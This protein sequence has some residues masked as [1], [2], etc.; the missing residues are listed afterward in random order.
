M[1]DDPH[2]GDRDPRTEDR[3]LLLDALLAA[4][5]RLIVTYTGNDE[6]TNI[7][8]PPAVP[9]GELLDVVD[10]TVRAADGPA[11]ERVVVRHPLQPFDPRNFTPGALAPERPWSFDRRHARRRAGAR[12]RPR[13]GPRR[14]S[15]SRC[16]RPARRS[17]SST[18]SSAS[19]STRCARSCASGSASALGDVSRRDRGRAAGRARRASS[20]GASA[21]GCSTASSPALRSTPASPPRSRAGR[22]RRAELAQP[23]IDRVRP[24]VE[25]I[26]GRR[27]TRARRRRRSPSSVDVKRRARRRPHAERD[28]PRRP[29]RR[30]AHRHLLARERPRTGSPPGC[31]CSR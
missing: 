30:P 16:R 2:V 20:A 24:I 22:C 26:A 7:A 28:G 31:G 13:R 23:V 6:R 9:V 3:Q 5:D 11:R 12:Q 21:S 27:A 15:P 10:A 18:T 14:S 29:R 19:S 25:E 17:S 1:L 4:T 8:R